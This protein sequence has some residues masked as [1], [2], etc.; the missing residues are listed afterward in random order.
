MLNSA[1]RLSSLWQFAATRLQDR[2][3]HVVIRI[4]VGEIRDPRAPRLDARKRAQRFRRVLDE[5]V[6]PCVRLPP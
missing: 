5:N 1:L 3:N 6:A 4:G 2:P